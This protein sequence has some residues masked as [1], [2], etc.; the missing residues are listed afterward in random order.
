MKSKGGG[1][2]LDG[3]ET[4]LEELRR[5]FKLDVDA[6]LDSIVEKAKLQHGE[7][8]ELKRTRDLDE[9]K[10][11]LEA[12]YPQLWEEHNQLMEEQRKY[13]ADTF[14]NGISRAL[15]AEG[16]GFRE[17]R[18]GLSSRAKEAVSDLHVKLAAD[19]ELQ[20]EF[21][22]VMKTVMKGGLVP[23]G[24]QGSSKKANDDDPEFDTSTPEGI[25]GNRAH[26]ATLIQKYQAEHPEAD[27]RTAMTAVMTQHKELAE[28]YRGSIVPA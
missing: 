24:E 4:Q 10:S 26:L 5:L 25:A 23:F 20:T 17:A 2:T 21:E 16:M 11:A 27:Y 1:N 18:L 8:V 15:K 3:T 6:D 22:T 12:E 14:V 19:K 13:K 9:Q 7:L 28:D